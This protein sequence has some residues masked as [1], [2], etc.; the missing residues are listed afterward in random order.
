MLSSV[1]TINYQG[2]DH[3]I[4]DGNPGP[5]AQALRKT[6]KEIQLQ[7]QPD[8]WGWVEELSL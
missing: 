4:G 6:L 8:R 3:Q 2:T 1:T 7:E 5:R